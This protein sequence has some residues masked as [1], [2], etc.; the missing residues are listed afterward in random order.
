MRKISC[1]DDKGLGTRLALSLVSR[2][3]FVNSF[4]VWTDARPFVLVTFQLWSD[5]RDGSWLT[6]PSKFSTLRSWDPRDAKWSLRATCVC[7]RVDLLT[8][9][10][11]S[12]AEGSTNHRICY[13][14]RIIILTSNSLRIFAKLIDN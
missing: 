8:S 12:R 5:L 2:T 14:R 10:Y 3:V 9:L 4:S 13:V 1:N 11:N 6:V 7:R